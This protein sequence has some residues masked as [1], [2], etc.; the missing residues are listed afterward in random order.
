MTNSSN[1]DNDSMPDWYD[2]FSEPN[3]IPSGWDVSDLTP[4]SADTPAEKARENQ[5]G[6]SLHR[7][8]VSPN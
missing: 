1:P 4:K 3:T 8:V 2:P 5:A 7:I 6:E